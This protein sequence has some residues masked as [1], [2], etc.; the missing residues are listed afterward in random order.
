MQSAHDNPNFQD[1][2]LA[3]RG[4]Q[5]SPVGNESK[6]VRSSNLNRYVGFADHVTASLA[7]QLT[8][9]SLASTASAD[10]FGTQARSKKKSK[11]KDKSKPKCSNAV[12][13]SDAGILM[14]S[15]N[16]NPSTMGALASAAKAKEFLRKLT[17]SIS[18][19][20]H[21]S[22]PAT[23]KKDGGLGNGSQS[24]KRDKSSKQQFAASSVASRT[25]ASFAPVR[26]RMASQRQD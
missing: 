1:P 3:L 20:S 2:R 25:E 10:A 17:T 9:G 6:N 15:E 12:Y 19:K 22:Q 7:V 5:T 13:S 4:S 8:G 26:G 11:N 16:R 21:N 14:G 24:T 18:V 23:P